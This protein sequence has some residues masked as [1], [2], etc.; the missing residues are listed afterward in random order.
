MNIGKYK[1]L[2][3]QLDKYC[4][5]WAAGHG[6]TGL[7]LTISSASISH[8]SVSFSV[9]YPHTLARCLSFSEFYLDK[10]LEEVKEIAEVM[11]KKEY[12]EGLARDKEIQDLMYKIQETAAYKELEKKVKEKNQFLSLKAENFQMFYL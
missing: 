6:Y 2:Q 8:G 10:T 5:A 4:K 11:R 3:E 1:E 12:E 7:S 9:C